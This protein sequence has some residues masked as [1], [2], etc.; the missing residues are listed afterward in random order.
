[1]Q[2]QANNTGPFRFAVDT[3]A[4]GMTRADSRLVRTM[5][6]LA[7]GSA[8]NFDGLQSA[9][10]TTVHIDSLSLGALRHR[11]ITA[12]AR[13]YSIRQLELAKFDGILARG[14]SATAC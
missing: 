12:I 5:A 10:A 9:E 1:M 13:D 8:L 14:S 4:S 11:D 6:L 3:G 2:A 7:G